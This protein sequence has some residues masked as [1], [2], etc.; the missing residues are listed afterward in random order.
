MNVNLVL[1]KKDG[2]TKS[3]PLPSTVTSIGRRQECDFCLPLGVVSRK[4][5]EIDI[6]RG[7]VLV[8][9]LNSRNGTLLNGQK[10]D[11]ARAQAGDLL[12]IG[13]VKFVVQI[14][15]KPESFDDYFEGPAE[16]AEKTSAGDFGESDDAG[17]SHSETTEILD[18]APDEFDIE[19]DLENELS[20]GS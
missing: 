14:G 2:T 11:E 3:F 16:S 20:K 6:D 19:S 7:Q 4:H 18:S 13:P 10:I 8:R 9:D 5:C 15:G 17:A 1:L 12:Q